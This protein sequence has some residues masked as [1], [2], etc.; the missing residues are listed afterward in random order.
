LEIFFNPKQLQFEK[1]QIQAELEQLRYKINPHFLFNTLNSLY[2]YTLKKSDLAPQMVLKISELMRYLLKD[3]NR[4]QVSLEQEIE[5]LKKYVDLEKLR[6]GD[7]FDVNFIVNGNLADKKIPPM[8]LLPLVENS[9]KHNDSETE[10]PFVNVVIDCNEER[11]FF[12]VENSKSSNET[13]NSSNHFSTGFGLENV[14]KRLNLIY[15]EGN[16]DLEIQ[17]FFDRFVVNLSIKTDK[18]R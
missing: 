7:K 18:M 2:S 17:S 3:E 6:F 13:P 12:Y 8:L 5:V 16:Y 1:N 9:F 15:G 4:E 14:K 11:F 10:R